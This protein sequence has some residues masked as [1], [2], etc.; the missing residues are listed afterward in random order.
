MLSTGKKVV[1][2]LQNSKRFASRLTYNQY[3]VPSEVVKL[4]KFD[5]PHIDKNSKCQSLT[6]NYC[7]MQK[8]WIFCL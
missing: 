4:E 8:N 5:E 1:N 7:L 3:G 2:L 6:F